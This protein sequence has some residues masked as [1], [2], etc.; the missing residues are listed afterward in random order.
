MWV[1]VCVPGWHAA[2]VV[3]VVRILSRIA[4]RGSFTAPKI[5]S[6]S[7]LLLLFIDSVAKHFK[8]A[9]QPYTHTHTVA[10]IHSCKFKHR[11]VPYS[12]KFVA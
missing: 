9:L 4:C 11:I 6:V 7:L 1:C 5:A 10:G 3:V 12:L 2:K 8:L